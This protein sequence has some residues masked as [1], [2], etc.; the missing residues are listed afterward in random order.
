MKLIDKKRSY[1]SIRY[2]GGYSDTEY[3]FD[4]SVSKDEFNNF[5]IEN[6]LPLEFKSD[7]WYK[8]DIE[9]HH[10]KDNVWIC[11]VKVPYLD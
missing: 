9:F 1:T 7:V 2:Q 11:R 6:K 5:C 4:T 8:G 10:P 3:T